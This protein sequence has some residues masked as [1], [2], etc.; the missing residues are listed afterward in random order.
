MVHTQ[1]EKALER[2]CMAYFPAQPNTHDV[3]NFN[4]MNFS[5]PP[6]LE[7]A[8]IDQKPFNKISYL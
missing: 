6:L 7:K 4:D 8:V 3:L 5:Y 2:M 1:C